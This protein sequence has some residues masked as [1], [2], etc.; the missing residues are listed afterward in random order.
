MCPKSLLTIG[1]Y[2]YNVVLKIKRGHQ[3]IIVI[4]KRGSVVYILNE[5]HCS[6]RREIKVKDKHQP[7]LLAV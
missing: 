4:M 2:Y 5:T 3:D 1:C 7:F 6:S